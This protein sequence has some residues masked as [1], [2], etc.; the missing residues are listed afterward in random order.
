MNFSLALILHVNICKIINVLIK[1]PK[2]ITNKKTLKHT[3]AL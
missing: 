3:V 1:T 2:T